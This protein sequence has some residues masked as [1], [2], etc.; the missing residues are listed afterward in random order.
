VPTGEKR[1]AVSGRS[2]RVLKVNP[3]RFRLTDGYRK[4]LRHRILRALL[5]PDNVGE[6]ITLHVC[7]LCQEAI[8]TKGKD[9]C[10]QLVQSRT[11]TV[12]SGQSS[13]IQL[14]VIPGCLFHRLIHPAAFMLKP[15]VMVTHGAVGRVPRT[16]AAHG[17]IR[18][19][20]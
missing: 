1:K 3:A 8:A 14:F 12:T 18:C 9:Q 11:T 2:Q 19:G 13:R 20:I 15:G 6:M 17:S 10:A 16:E 7:R 5:N 4:F